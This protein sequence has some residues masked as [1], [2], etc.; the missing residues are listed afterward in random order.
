MVKRAAAAH[1]HELVRIVEKDFVI[2]EFIPVYQNLAKD[3]TQESIRSSCVTASVA[4]CEVFNQ[5]EC[6]SYLRDT[7]S[8]LAMDQ[9][10]RVRLGMAKVYGKVCKSIG[11]ESMVSHLVHPLIELMQDQEPDVRKAAVSALEETCSLLTP[12]QVIAY[13]VP[14]FPVISKDPVQQ[15][16]S[17]LSA[18][19][20]PLSISLGDDFTLEYLV[21]LLTDSV[22]DDSPTIRF[23][24]T[25]SIGAI[26]QVLK[27]S[28]QVLHQMVSLLHLLA[29][30]SNWRTRLAVLEQIP[31]LCKLHGREF[32]ESKLENLFLSF[33]G[34]SV[35]AVRA[36]LT[37]QIG[38]LAELLGEGWTV[39]HFLQKILSLYSPA[40]SYSSRIAILQTLGKLAV[41]I[42]DGNDIQALLSPTLQKGCSDPVA[43]VR[44]TAC[45]VVDDI[46]K[47]KDNRSKTVGKFIKPALESLIKDNDIDVRYFASR[48]VQR[49]SA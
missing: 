2:T 22:K 45:S 6:V 36:A 49:T 13:I 19:I 10:W 15:V 29:Q 9:S 42:H 33:F 18:C 35:H 31:V 21:P 3:E 34:D 40:S 12:P 14:L 16:R 8:S 20:G 38:I 28:P 4:L 41:V 17:A 39:K 1:L 23:N 46:M 48:A 24:A 5:D 43:N 25:A 7:L 44:F 37:V 30:D 11:R 26:C 27:D 47:L 32:F